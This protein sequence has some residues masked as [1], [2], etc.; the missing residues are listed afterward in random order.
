MATTRL[1][2]KVYKR[3]HRHYLDLD[4]Y[5]HYQCLNYSRLFVQSLFVGNRYLLMAHHLPLLQQVREFKYLGI[6]L[7]RST[8]HRFE[9]GRFRRFHPIYMF[10]LSLYWGCSILDLER[11]GSDVLRG[12]MPNIEGIQ[13]PDIESLR[14]DAMQYY[15]N[16]NQDTFIGFPDAIK[17]CFEAKKKAAF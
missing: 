2:S 6:H 16:Y 15:N 13:Q 4:P 14:M 11:I 1:E 5:L 8:L 9:T 17:R 7:V 10:Y 3:A 12:A